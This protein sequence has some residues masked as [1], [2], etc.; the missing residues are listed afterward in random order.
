[1]I[2]ILF[3][4]LSYKQVFDN[5][6]NGLALPAFQRLA[7]QAVLFRDVVPAGYHTQNVLPSLLIG[8]VVSR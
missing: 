3:D 5:P 6:A 2:W 8:S 7:S 4:E 1:M